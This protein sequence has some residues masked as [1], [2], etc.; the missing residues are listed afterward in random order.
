MVMTTGQIQGTTGS[1]FWLVKSSSAGATGYL[2]WSGGSDPVTMGGR[3]RDRGAAGPTEG[4]PTTN[5]AA[6]A[7]VGG[8]VGATQTQQRHPT[9]MAPGEG[10]GTAMMSGG[11]AGRT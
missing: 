10:G 1:S 11:G 2:R 7:C 4:P 5:G 6:V 8:P 9:G 3:G